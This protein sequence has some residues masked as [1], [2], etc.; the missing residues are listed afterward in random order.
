MALDEGRLGQFLFLGVG[1]RRTSRRGPRPHAIDRL[2]SHFGA[3][4]L[5]RPFVRGEIAANNPS[6][7]DKAGLGRRP[8]VHTLQRRWQGNTIT[9][10]WLL[11]LLLLPAEML[12]KLCVT[13]LHVTLRWPSLVMIPAV[14]LMMMKILTV[15]LLLVPTLLLLWHRIHRNAHPHMRRSVEV[16]NLPVRLRVYRRL[17]VHAMAL[18]A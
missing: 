4:L 18:H 7:G 17:H 15:L 10:V 13:A 9:T 5:A 14:L 1:R 11:L 2:R 8:L 12:R 16:S 6:V 3:M